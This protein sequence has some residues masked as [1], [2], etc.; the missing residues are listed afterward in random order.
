VPK[1]RLSLKEGKITGRKTGKK[2]PCVGCKGEIVDN[3]K[4]LVCTQCGTVH[5]GM[6]NGGLFTTR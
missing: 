4:E 6:L 5:Y 3:G 2:C 1:R